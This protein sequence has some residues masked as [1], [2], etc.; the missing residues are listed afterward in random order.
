MARRSRYP[1]VLREI[2]RVEA[3]SD[4]V[5]AFAA[6]LLV[7]DLAVPMDLTVPG[8]MGLW[9]AIV[10][11]WPSYLAFALSFVIVVIFWGNHHQMLKHVRYA[12]PLFMVLNGLILMGIAF[13]P[14][15]T[16]MLADYLLDPARGIV[17]TALY[18]GALW[19][20][21]VGLNVVWLYV[22]RHP[23][24]LTPDT[25]PAAVRYHSRYYQL[26][27]CLRTLSVG[28]AFV[29]VPAC[30]VLLLLISLFY[31]VPRG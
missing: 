22:I 7:A 15:A 30:L 21:S 29:N 3:F 26:S 8:A 24:L 20:V 14:H 19:L 18:A 13:V 23:D 1:R 17:A 25:N 31:L 11:N 12:D 4:G 6:T 5:F 2:N 9:W 10:A 27:L 28:L 16:A